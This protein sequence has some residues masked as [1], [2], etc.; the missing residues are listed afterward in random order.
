MPLE[1]K[2]RKNGREI[3]EAVAKRID[4]L[5]S[6]LEHRNAELEKLMADKDKLRSYL[7]RSTQH[8]FSH[9]RAP[10]Q[11]YS[12]NDISSEEKEEMRQMC[13]RIFEIEQ[14]IHR[15]DFDSHTLEGQ[16]GVRIAFR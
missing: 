3:R 9:G 11:L 8:E 12:K 14:E 5:K 6:R 4:Q 2:F 15:A 1:I 10:S 16:S 13:R 7:I